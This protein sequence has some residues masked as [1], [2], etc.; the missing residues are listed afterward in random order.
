MS[1]GICDSVPTNTFVSAVETI[2]RIGNGNSA[3]EVE[4]KMSLKLPSPSKSVVKHQLDTTKRKNGMST[5][6]AWLK[7]VAV[8]PFGL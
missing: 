5:I 4:M 7:I 1:D 8:E 2:T 3:Y 6:A